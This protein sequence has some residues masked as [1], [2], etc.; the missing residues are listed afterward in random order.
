MTCAIPNKNFSGSFAER[1]AQLGIRSCFLVVQHMSV[2]ATMS[3]CASSLMRNGY[4]IGPPHVHQAY[5]AQ[6]RP[7]PVCEAISDY[8]LFD[9]GMFGYAF[10]LKI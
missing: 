1:G 8:T 5:V 2:L 3:E 4:R 6:S 7:F 9:G 10:R